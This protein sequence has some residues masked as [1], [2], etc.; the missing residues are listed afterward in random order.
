MFAAAQ[1]TPLGRMPKVAGFSVS[2]ARAETP[3]METAVRPNVIAQ[4]VLALVPGQ[5]PVLAA[6]REAIAAWAGREDEVDAH[7]LADIAL[8][9]PL[10]C[11]RVLQHVAS[12]LGDR[13]S[14]RVQTVTSALV[15]TGIEP[16]FRAFGDLP[17]LEDRLAHDPAALAGARAAI[18]IAHASARIAAAFAV[19]RNDGDAELLHQG[20][21][22]HDFPSILLWVEAPHA[23]AA[24]PR[25]LREQPQLRTLQAQT[26]LLGC[27][28]GWLGRRLLQDWGLHGA[29]REAARALDENGSAAQTV[30][31][32]V[33]I[34]RHLELGWQHPVVQEDL[35]AAGAELLNLPG[36]GVAH[37]VA[38]ALH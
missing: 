20:A 2:A 13:L 15:L 27:D 25:L 18:D 23:A 3:S 4:R 33:R 6:S 14:N 12:T 9:D 37:L 28:L 35:R 24:I 16:F 11:L 36:P 31:F 26:M 7:R 32:A 21:L 34:A 29:V 17:T 1:G 19:H 38:D 5:L 30:R 22:L 10:L 8:R